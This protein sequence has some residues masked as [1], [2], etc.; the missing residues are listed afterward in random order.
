MG[1][2]ELR[3]LDDEGL[4]LPSPARGKTSR[5]LL[6]VLVKGEKFQV[7]QPSRMRRPPWPTGA[8][9]VALHERVIRAVQRA[10]AY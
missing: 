1:R 7:T 10:W 6:Q 8:A 9:A 2:P 5:W 3:S 4:P